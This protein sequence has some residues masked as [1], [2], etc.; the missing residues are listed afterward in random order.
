MSFCYFSVKKIIAFEKAVA[1]TEYFP[2]PDFTVFTYV[3]KPDST[4]GIN[5]VFI[6]YCK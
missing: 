6:S 2:W 4:A 1:L 3:Q 5:L